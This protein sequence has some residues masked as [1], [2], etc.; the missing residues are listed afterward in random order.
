MVFNQDFTSGLA[1]PS[2]LLDYF[3]YLFPPPES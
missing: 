2:P 1:Q 3:P